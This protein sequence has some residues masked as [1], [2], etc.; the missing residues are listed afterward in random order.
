PL[1]G[2]FAARARGIA[3]QPLAAVSSLGTR[4]TIGAG[5]ELLLETYI[6]DFDGDLYGCELEIEFVARL[7]DEVQFADL[8]SL[9]AQMRRDSALARRILAA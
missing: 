5:G 6:F 3:A 7:R 4:P 2:I 1:R 8:P 9:V